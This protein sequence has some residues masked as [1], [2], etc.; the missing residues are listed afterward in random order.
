[1]SEYSL[2]IENIEIQFSNCMDLGLEE[3]SLKILFVLDWVLGKF[4]GL[5]KPIILALL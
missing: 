3:N 4:L 5:L 2:I 1:M